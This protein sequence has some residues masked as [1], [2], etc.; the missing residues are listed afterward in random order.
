MLS[1]RC[2]RWKYRCPTHMLTLFRDWKKLTF[3]YFADAYINF[4]PLVTDLF[5]IYKTRIWMSAINPASFITPSTGLQ[6]PSV[7]GPGA[8]NQDS[9]TYPDRR[10]QKHNPGFS[11][12]GP[13]QLAPGVFDRTW[14]ANRDASAALGIP[15]PHIYAPS[16]QP[17]ELDNR[18][19]EQFPVEYH[20][21]GQQAVPLQSRY[22]SSGYNVPD[23]DHSS[24]AISSDNNNAQTRKPYALGGEWSH[25]FQGLSLGS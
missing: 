13:S 20:H 5:K 16:L 4:N 17:Q 24:Y 19:L 7:L 22:S 15:F 9:E 11:I 1:S 3:Y 14:D 25:A 8:F 23:L 6:L 10:P 2:K 21:G 12:A 18:Q